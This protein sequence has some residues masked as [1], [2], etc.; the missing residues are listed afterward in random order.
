MPKSQI[1][2]PSLLAALVAAAV[3]STIAAGPLAWFAS[4]AG[5]V[6]LFVLF[7]YDQ[8]G[9]RS[10]SQSLAFSAVCGFCVALA[11][12]GVAQ[13]LAAH[14]EVHVAA[15]GWAA[16][17]GPL[18][19]LFATLILW[20]IDRSRM[21]AR[22]GAAGKQRGR[23]APGQHVLFSDVAP[24]PS[25]SVPPAAPVPPVAPV[26]RAA[27]APVE[28]V[29]TPPPPVQP[30]PI[31]AAPV[32]AASGPAPDLVEAPR[33]G[34]APIIPRPGKTT[35]IYVTLLGEGMNV[36]RSVTAEHLGRDFYRITDTMP[37]GE[38]WEFQPG[39]VV[40][41]KKRNL[42]S[43]KALVAIEEAPRAQ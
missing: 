28:T 27:A 20:A 24:A 39:Q 32:E 4:I 37:E 19:C 40:R 14:G 29:W 17:W 38:T 1:G 8:D 33:F 36:L 18:V 12:S 11:C 7:A 16:E 31:Q 6:L 22:E 41:C 43:G 13:V 3:A 15:G 26:I 35:S 21:S 42:S 10:A 5:L 34:P 9:Y 2:S 30:P 25:P 23:V